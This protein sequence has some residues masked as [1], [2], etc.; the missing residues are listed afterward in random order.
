MAELTPPQLK[1]R[2][3]VESAIRLAAPLFNAVLEVGDRVSRIVAP[4]D[5]EYYPT[6]PVEQGG[7]GS[8]VTAK[9]TQAGRLHSE[10]D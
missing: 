10:G 4:N 6:P 8:K 2:A 5:Y 9:R 1:T 3:R 7:A